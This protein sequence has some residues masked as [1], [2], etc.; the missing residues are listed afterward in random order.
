MKTRFTTIFIYAMMA[1]LTFGYTCALRLGL[2]IFN[3]LYDPKQM[4]ELNTFSTLTAGLG[5]IEVWQYLAWGSLL[6]GLAWGCIR[7]K[8]GDAPDPHMVPWVCHLTFIL[9]AFFLNVTGALSPLV[10]PAYVIP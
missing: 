5:M 9:A 7:A 3:I 1:L 2:S 6:I 4:G 10:M 8:H